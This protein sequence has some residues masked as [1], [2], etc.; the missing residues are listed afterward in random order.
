VSDP[1]RALLKR[2]FPNHRVPEREELVR[3]PAPDPTAH[4]IRVGL[5]Q[6]HACWGYLRGK[7]RQSFTPVELLHYTQWTEVRVE[8]AS[9]WDC[10]RL[11]LEQY[12]PMR[13]RMETACGDS[14]TA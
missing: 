7:S 9:A 12:E 3:P 10:A 6:P 8:G 11:Y 14:G 2:L 1:I 13:L 4:G 5:D